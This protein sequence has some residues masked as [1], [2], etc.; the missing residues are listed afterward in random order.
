MFLRGV[1]QSVAFGIGVVM[2]VA[3]A[4]AV[5]TE[6]GDPRIQ[7]LLI[8]KKLKHRIDKDG[9]FKVVLDTQPGRT[10]LVF[11]S[12]RTH[13]YGPLEIRE[14]WSP[15]IQDDDMPAPL[16]LRLLQKNDVVKLGAWRVS[17]LS[18]VKTAVFAAQVDANADGDSLLAALKA[19]STGADEIERDVVGGDRF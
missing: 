11:I 19:V 7:K 3:S 18:G 1:G 9:D 10:Q 5:D 12:S 17:T 14:V 6:A 16:T 8:E 2:L 15:A 13:E 4:R